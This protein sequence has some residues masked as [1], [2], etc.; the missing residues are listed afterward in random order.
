TFEDWQVAGRNVTFT[1]KTLTLDGEPQ[2]AKGTLK[3]YKLKSPETVQ[4]PNLFGP[5][6]PVTRRGRGGVPLPPAPAKPAPA[7]PHTCDMGGPPAKGSPRGRAS[8]VSGPI[9]PARRFR[10]NRRSMKAGAAG[11]RCAS[12]TCARTGPTSSRGSWTCPGATRT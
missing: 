12:P 1:V 4:R 5:K 10:S 2:A 3:V 11:S 8:R 9:R 7:D 6:T